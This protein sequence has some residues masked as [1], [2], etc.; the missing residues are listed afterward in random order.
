[1]FVDSSNLAPGTYEYFVRS[2]NGADRTDYVS[3]GKITI[4]GVPTTPPG[5][6]VCSVFYSNGRAVVSWA[7]VG[8]ARSYQVRHNGFWQTRTTELTWTDDS[9]GNG[10]YTVE[11]VFA[12]EVKSTRT[13]C[14][15]VQPPT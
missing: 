13:T 10:V 9:P 6:P 1:M 2:I 14:K 3:C 7:A 11:A 15:V 8:G 4:P 5:P 12:N